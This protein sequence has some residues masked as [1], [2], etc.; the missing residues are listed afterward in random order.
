MN[1]CSI[2][3][4]EFPNSEQHVQLPCCHKY[5]F[6]CIFDNMK[7]GIKPNECPM[8]REEIKDYNNL[9]IQT[10]PSTL[11]NLKKSQKEVINMHNQLVNQ[12]EN[13]KKINFNNFV[14]LLQTINN[15]TNILIT[16]MRTEHTNEE[17]TVFRTRSHSGTI[18]SNFRQFARE[19]YQLYE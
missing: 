17:Q 16:R 11:T 4:D 13:N 7:R 9:L 6:K 15:N 5:H 18:W 14:E 8:C 2:C 19:A 1:T 10:D 3:L 12:L